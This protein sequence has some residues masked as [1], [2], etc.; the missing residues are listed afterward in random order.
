MYP[1]RRFTGV[2][3][4]GCLESPLYYVSTYLLV[5]LPFGDLPSIWPMANRYH[6][7]PQATILRKHLSYMSAGLTSFDG[8]FFFYGYVS[9][10]GCARLQQDLLSIYLMRSK[11]TKKHYIHEFAT[12][13]PFLREHTYLGYLRSVLLLVKPVVWC[14]RCVD[15]VRPSAGR[16]H[17]VRL[18]CGL[19]PIRDWSSPVPSSDLHLLCSGTASPLAPQLWTLHALPK[20][21]LSTSHSSGPPHSP[22]FPHLTSTHK[23]TYTQFGKHSPPL[24]HWLWH[25]KMF[26]IWM[27]LVCLSCPTKQATS[28]RTSLWAQNSK[29]P[30]HSCFCCKHNK[31]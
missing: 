12:A 17:P 14:L 21:L 4:F 22:I 31:H 25:W 20:L 16:N 8:F 15:P 30:S 13:N 19:W 29:G 9:F 5:C 6:P 1:L 26:T 2:C 24:S 10:L 11:I 18:C 27:R 7:V 28:A 23:T 3:D